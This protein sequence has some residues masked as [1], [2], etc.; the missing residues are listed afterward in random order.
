MTAQEIY[1]SVPIG[2]RLRFSD[3]QPKPKLRFVQKLRAWESRNGFGKL[4]EKH[5]P[6][7]GAPAYFVLT[8]DLGW[9]KI[10]T[11]YRLD[12]RLRFDVVFMPPGAETSVHNAPGPSEQIANP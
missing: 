10:N 5:R 4:T 1:D 7:G 11:L 2:A 9:L 8:T 12:S 3:G 6:D